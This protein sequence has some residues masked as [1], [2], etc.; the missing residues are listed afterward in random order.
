MYLNFKWKLKFSIHQATLSVVY[1][2]PLR[3]RGEFGEEWH[4]PRGNM[5]LTGD[6]QGRLF[7]R[8]IKDLWLHLSALSWT[9]E[10]E[11][12]EAC[13]WAHSSAAGKAASCRSNQT[14][15]GGCTTAIDDWI[16]ISYSIFTRC[17]SA[18][19]RWPG[20]LG[21]GMLQLTMTCCQTER[22][23]TLLFPLQFFFLIAPVFNLITFSHPQTGTFWQP[24][25]RQHIIK[26]ITQLFA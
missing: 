26:K 8:M 17:T 1:T 15:V 13:L 2:P 4:I 10:V 11:Q 24:W 6:S 9:A 3:L 14:R 25:K 21:N 7:S 16:A 20:T 12:R 23:G 18:P 22:A 5:W 19:R